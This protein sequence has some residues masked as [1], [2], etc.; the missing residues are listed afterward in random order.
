MICHVIMLC[1]IQVHQDMS[2]HR[3]YCQ[4]S[5]H[6]NISVLYNVTVHFGVLLF[7]LMFKLFDLFVKFWCDPLTSELHTPRMYKGNSLV[8]FLF[9]TATVLVAEDSIFC[10]L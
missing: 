2:R 5:Q 8:P 7:F 4:Q 9:T 3:C 1:F 10:C 6:G